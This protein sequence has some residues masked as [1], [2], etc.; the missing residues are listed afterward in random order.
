MKKLYQKN[1]ITVEVRDPMREDFL[2]R[3]GWKLV[4]V[5]EETPALELEDV[6]DLSILQLRSLA[7]ER[8][9]K[10]YTN[11]SKNDLLDLLAPQDEDD[12]SIDE[13]E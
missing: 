12:E 7:K 3:D 9:L 8:G 5:V 4:E 10:G 6:S 2:T 13:E 1:G 11:M